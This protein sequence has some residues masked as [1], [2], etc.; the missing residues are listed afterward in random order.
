MGN[1]TRPF[2]V[3]YKRPKRQGK[4]R[5]IIN[6]LKEA[7]RVKL[8]GKEDICHEIVSMDDSCTE[9]YKQGND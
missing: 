8:K 9:E 7:A 2:K 1:L 4:G 6:S 3:Y 5:G